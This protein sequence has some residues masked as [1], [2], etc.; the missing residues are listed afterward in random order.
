MLDALERIQFE[1]L[2][3]TEGFKTREKEHDTPYSLR[4]L[5][6]RKDSKQ[7]FPGGHITMG[8]RVLLIRKDSKQ[9]R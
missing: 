3:N 5:L 8:L 2:V 1:S 4:V 9:R 6:I 7:Q